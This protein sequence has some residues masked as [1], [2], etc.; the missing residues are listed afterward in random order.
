VLANK[1]ITPNGSNVTKFNPLLYHFNITIQ[2]KFK[3]KVIPDHLN[4]ERD[5]I[6][7]I[8]KLLQIPIADHRKCDLAYFG[9]LPYQMYKIHLLIL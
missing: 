9:A 3:K 7:W 2:Q 6:P 1:E 8:D 5:S 4:K